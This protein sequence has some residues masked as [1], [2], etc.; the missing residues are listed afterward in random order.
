MT[1]SAVSTS[2]S[3]VMN[4]SWTQTSKI[5]WF[6]YVARYLTLLVLFPSEPINSYLLIIGLNWE[7]L[8]TRLKAA[9]LCAVAQ[10]ATARN[11]EI[12]DRQ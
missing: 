12:H 5:Y 10:F 8:E 2:F 6:D 9:K 11:N 7:K 1:L 4:N 3:H